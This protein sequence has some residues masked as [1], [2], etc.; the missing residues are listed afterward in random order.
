M[1]AFEDEDSIGGG[2]VGNEVSVGA[3]VSGGEF[4]TALECSES[5]NRCWGVQRGCLSTCMW[6][7]EQQCFSKILVC[8]WVL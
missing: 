6:A 2:L 5:H 1:G 4:R 8:L 7:S 3:G